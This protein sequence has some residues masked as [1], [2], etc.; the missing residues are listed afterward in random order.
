M[1]ANIIYTTDAFVYGTEFDDI[2]HLTDP[3]PHYVET[4]LGND[5]VYGNA[6]TDNVDGEEGNDRLFGFGGD[7]I[8]NGGDGDDYVSG[9]TGSDYVQGGAGAD[10]VFGGDGDD[11]VE[12]GIHELQT[13]VAFGPAEALNDEMHGGNGSD[14]VVADIW[15]IGGGNKMWGD[16][17]NDTLILYDFETLGAA[18]TASNWMYGGNGNDLLIA[19]GQGDDYIDGGSGNDTL[20][21]NSSDPYQTVDAKITVNLGL[22]AAQDVGAYGIDTIRNI[23]NVVGT[24]G[25]DTITGSSAANVLNGLD[26]A[27]TISGAGG[28]DLL[29]GGRGDDILTGGRGSDSFVFE[30]IVDRIRPP[31]Y[32]VNSAG[33]D[34]VT[35]FNRGQGDHIKMVAGTSFIG[36]TA[37]HAAGAAEVRFDRVGNVSALSYDY[38][39]DGVTDG[40]MLVTSSSVL[41]AADFLFV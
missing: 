25:D 40:S 4:W 17:G 20:D 41:T 35:D 32:Y 11:T 16:G 9:G 10:K 23:E 21:Y 15:G 26:G 8:L 38:N 36:A 33:V 7:D 6:A 31:P 13:Q 5:I 3:N 28:N 27:D 37:F 18:K 30:A 34:T 2:I 22:T 19:T 12:G 14:L 1:P 39:G 24:V 29:V